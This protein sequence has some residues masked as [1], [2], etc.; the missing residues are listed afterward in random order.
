M[1]ADPNARARTAL[2]ATPTPGANAVAKTV[3]QLLGTDAIKRRF[4][5]ILGN[6]APG[7]ISSI[8]NVTNGSRMLK[9]CDPTTI[10]SAAAIAASLDLPIDPNLGFAYI[11]PYK[12][13]GAQIAEGQFQMGY[14]GYVQLGLRSGQYRSIHTGVVY[15][16]EILAQTAQDRLT[17]RLR[18]SGGPRASDRVVAAASYFG[19]LNGAEMWDYISVEEAE[20]HG[21]KYSKSYARDSSPWKTQFNAMMCKTS[22]KRLLRHYGPLSIQMQTAVLADQSVVRSDPG[23]PVADATFD[24]VDGTDASTDDAVTPEARAFFG[25]SEA[26]GAVTAQEEPGANG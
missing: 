7:F 3:A 10:V 8:I 17:G 11:V 22:L 12:P 4:E 6:R 25:R 24:Y 5:E 16:G 14:L 2:A 9:E 20:A 1:A 13:S 15:D 18:F 19:L 23:A 26:G 21:R